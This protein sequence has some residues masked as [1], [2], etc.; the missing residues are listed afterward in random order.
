MKILA[1]QKSHAGKNGPKELKV[2]LFVLFI[3]IIYLFFFDAQEKVQGLKEAFKEALTAHV[4]ESE[5]EDKEM[6]D[7]EIEFLY[8]KVAHA[9]K[10]SLK[11]ALKTHVKGW[12]SF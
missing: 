6:E 12:Y 7:E 9:L 11:E 2:L 10:E 4:K 8:T 3:V 1:N 5:D